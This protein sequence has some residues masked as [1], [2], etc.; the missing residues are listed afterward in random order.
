MVCRQI[1]A[2]RPF[3]AAALLLPLLSPAGAEPVASPLAVR[4]AGIRASREI[5]LDGDKPER[6]GM[7]MSA[8]SVHL[9]V[10]SRDAGLVEVAKEKSALTAFRDDKG[11]DL[12][13]SKPKFGEV[14]GG[15]PKYAKDR[16]SCLIEVQSDA[17][18]AP[19]ARSLTLEGTLVFTV[20]GGEEAVK[21][22]GVK[23]STGATLKAGALSLT[24]EKAG[25]PD[26]GDDPLAVTIKMSAATNPVSR[27]RFLDAAGQEIPSRRTSTSSMRMPGVY[28]I[29]WEYSLKK[30]VETASVEVTL[31]K[32]LQEM[33]VPV[34]LE[35][36][37]GM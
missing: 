29:N 4:V 8:T 5:Q 35:F 16:R 27:I 17:L 12:L 21:S 25:K 7:G 19:G 11:T 28:V 3:R 20:A 6:A 23:L 14:L 31:W 15:F 33:T 24:V 1:P 10:E 2:L 32:D 34:K 36:G 26:W 30:A 37:I 18:P 13:A 9:L 22:E